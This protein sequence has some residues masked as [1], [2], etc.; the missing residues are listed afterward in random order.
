MRIPDDAE[1]HGAQKLV[2]AANQTTGAMHRQIGVGP[3][4]FSGFR[5]ARATRGTGTTYHLGLGETIRPTNRLCRWGGSPLVL[6]VMRK[7]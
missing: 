1:N 7:R 3:V 5:K 4:A 6:I 2:Q